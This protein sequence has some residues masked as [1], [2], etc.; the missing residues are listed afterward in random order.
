ME[1]FIQA[2]ACNEN[3]E[4]MLYIMFKKQFL[5]A[6]ELKER[7][8]KFQRSLPSS[9]VHSCKWMRNVCCNVLE[10]ERLESQSQARVEGCRTRAADPVTPGLAEGNDKG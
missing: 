1:R 7:Q 4:A 3:D 10:A 2:G 9:S 5:K 8:A 6:S